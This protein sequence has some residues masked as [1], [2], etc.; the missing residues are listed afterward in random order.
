MTRVLVPLTA[1]MA[2]ACSGLGDTATKTY[3]NQAVSMQLMDGTVI[4]DSDH[5]NEGDYD[6]ES[7][8]T[9]QSLSWQPIDPETTLEQD[10]D[11]YKRAMVEILTSSP[12][13]DAP[14]T[15]PDAQSITVSGQPGTSWTIPIGPSQLTSA[16]WDCPAAGVRITLTTTALMGASKLQQTSLDSAVCKTEL[17]AAQEVHTYR[18]LGAKSDWTETAAHSNSTEYESIDGSVFVTVASQNSLMDPELPE[19]CQSAMNLAIGEMTNGEVTLDPGKERQADRP[20]GCSRDW[21]GTIAMGGT[22]KGRFEH[23]AC[24]QDGYMLTC[25]VTDER[26]VNEVCTGLAGCP[27]ATP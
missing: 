23:R 26:T 9:S 15:M 17:V 2:L 21:E 1:L 18:F 27:V 16:M 3:A 20:D 22:M 5:G 4:T 19:L 25:I 10:F 12:D 24:G 6:L 11:L 14:A 8:L 13:F 7:G